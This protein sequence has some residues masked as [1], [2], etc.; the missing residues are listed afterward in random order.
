M[1]RSDNS[2]LK[3]SP[4]LM[5]NHNH[6]K[7]RRSSLIKVRMVVTCRHSN[8]TAGNNTKHI[9]S[10]RNGKLRAKNAKERSNCNNQLQI[11]SNRK[12]H[13]MKTLA[14]TPCPSPQTRCANWPSD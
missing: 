7:R 5:G 10:N 2:R 11:N 6:K 12:I 14:T 9:P 1:V 3:R 4:R 8:Q 13:P